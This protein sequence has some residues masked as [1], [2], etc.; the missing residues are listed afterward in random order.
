MNHAADP[1][2]HDQSYSWSRIKPRNDNVNVDYLAINT[3]DNDSFWYRINNHHH[4][5][6]TNESAFK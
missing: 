2:Y 4:T 6:W 1:D 5:Y 3:H